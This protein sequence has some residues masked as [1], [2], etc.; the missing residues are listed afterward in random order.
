MDR[1]LEQMDYKGIFE[2]FSQISRIPRGSGNEAEISDFLVDFA[3]GLGL[4]YRQDAAKNVIIIKEASIGYEE[5]P[6]ILLQ[7]HMDMVCEKTPESNHDFETDGI[8]LVIDGEYL[9]ADQT[10]LGADNGVALAYMMAILADTELK[11]PRIEAIITTD[12]EVGMHGAH[13]L[14][15]TGLKAKYMINL[16]SEEEGYLLT[17]CA[18]GLR[19]TCTIPVERV[20]AKGKLVKFNLT[21]L[22]GGHSGIDIIYNRANANKLLGRALY[23][24]REEFDFDVVSMEGGFKDNVIPREANVQMLLTVDSSLD[25]DSAKKVA[26]EKYAALQGK[27]AAIMAD[28]QK[29]MASSEPDL[30]YTL[31][32]LGDGMDMVLHPVSFEK[33]LFMLMHIPNGIQVMSS[34]IEGLVESSLNL[35][36]FYIDEEEAVFTDAV[37]SSFGSYKKHISNQLEYLVN[38]LGGDY[39]VRA[40]YP[41]WEYRT[42]S[43]LRNHMQ[44]IHQEMYGKKMIVQAIHAG[45]E[46]GLIFEKL[47]GID[48]VSIGP[49]MERVHTVDEKLHI[50]STIRVYKFLER[51]LEDKIQ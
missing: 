9:K 22:K 19:T 35:G 36:I 38:F 1:I 44:K 14:D 30:T 29:E 37:R 21:G 17:S 4:E 49:D 3:K 33:V 24:L 10:T 15:C 43:P 5:Q 31:E 18:G 47:P 7:G 20:E 2:Y 11:H 6:A 23:E 13:A 12:E 25:E 51:V 16:D 26:N 28:M 34:N 46:C 48:I 8:R 39:E 50:P 32:D 27:I 40:D 41:A 45:L 42:E